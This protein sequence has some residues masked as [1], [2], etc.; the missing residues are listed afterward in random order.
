MIVRLVLGVLAG[1]LGAGIVHIVGVLA[2]PALSDAGLF[3]RIEGLG[4]PGRFHPL[5]TDDPF[6]LAV[7]CAAPTD[8]PRRVVSDDPVPGEIDFWSASVFGPD[9]GAIYSLN[10]RTAIEGRFD[11]ILATPAAV[12]EMRAELDESAPELVAVPERAVV[13][14]RT[15][16]TEPTLRARAE[17]FL[18]SASCDPL[19]MG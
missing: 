1:L 3:E 14:L 10:D 11:L 19:E 15:R 18:A 5:P 8:E 4:A 12:A 17:A 2:V 16:V 13:V 7:A 6:A 9:G